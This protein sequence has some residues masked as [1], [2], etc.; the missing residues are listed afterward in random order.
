[1]LSAQIR[2]SLAYRRFI[3]VV[4]GSSFRN[5]E[6]RPQPARNTRRQLSDLWCCSGREVSAYQRPAAYHTASRP[7]VAR[8]RL[9]LNESPSADSRYLTSC[10]LHFLKPPLV[11]SLA[12]VIV[13]LDDRVLI[14]CLFNCAQL[15]S[16]FSEVAQSLDAISG[17]QFHAGGVRLGKPWA[18]GTVGVSRG[19]VM[20]QGWLRRLVQLW[21]RFSNKTLVHS[22]L[23]NEAEQR[24]Q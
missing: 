20:R 19:S 22:L 11:D 9:E 21:D 10:G 5:E 17:I 2:C 14:I 12:T 7:P 15:P 23:S 4:L 18:F 13:P 24:P 1:M 6:R 3:S 8:K 16:R